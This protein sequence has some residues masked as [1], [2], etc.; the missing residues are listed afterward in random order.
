MASAGEEFWVR[1][2]ADSAVT[3]EREIGNCKGKKLGEVNTSLCMIDV[4]LRE[5]EGRKCVFQRSYG[6]IHCSRRVK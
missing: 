2:K 6:K 3:C 4:G 5:M 1:G